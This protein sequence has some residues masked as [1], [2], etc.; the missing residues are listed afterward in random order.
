MRTAEGREVSAPH[1]SAGDRGT[2]GP[3]AATSAH[4]T[5]PLETPDLL[6]VE[7]PAHATPSPKRKTPARIANRRRTIVVAGA[8]NRGGPTRT[9][10][11]WRCGSGLRCRGGGESSKRREMP[12]DA[13][14]VR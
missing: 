7:N 11:R 1:V 12:G 8:P 6:E 13:G 2:E 9:I 4:R 14:D 5:S 10:S 3:Q